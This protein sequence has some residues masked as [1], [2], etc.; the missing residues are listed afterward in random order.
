MVDANIPL[1]DAG[2]SPD[3]KVNIS[4]AQAGR[5]QLVLW[6][7][8][9]TNIIIGGEDDIARP[10]ATH[11]YSLLLT[12]AELRGRRLVCTYELFPPASGPNQPYYTR[13]DFFQNNQPITPAPPNRTEKQGN[14]G[15]NGR[16]VFFTICEF[17]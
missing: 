4:F 16:A 17:V 6:K 1:P 7:A 12:P 13:L 5:Y 8:D 3:V 15:S 14:F 9:H 10:G 11:R 2:G